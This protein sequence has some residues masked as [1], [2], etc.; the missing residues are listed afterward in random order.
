[1]NE[2]EIQLNPHQLSLLKAARTEY[3]KTA[4]EIEQLT[5]QNKEDLIALV[6][7]L[8]W[9][10]KTHKAQIKALRAGF[11]LYAKQQAE[12]ALKNAENANTIATL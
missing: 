10:T 6:D 8:G 4:R 5:L 2:F 3:A 12:E 1:M 7:G 9:E 11:K